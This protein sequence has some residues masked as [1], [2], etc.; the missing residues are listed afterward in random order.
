MKPITI[1]GGGLAGLTLGILLR[2]EDIPV[3]IIEAGRYPRHRVCGEFLSG[4]GRQI[5]QQLDVEPKLPHK[6]EASTCSFHVPNRPAIRFSLSKPALCVSRFALDAALADEFE[7]LGGVLKTGERAEANAREEGIVRATGRRRAENTH[8]R[9][10]GLKAHALGAPV[11][12]DLEMHFG[13]H[14]YVGLCR[15]ADAR[16]NV[17]GLFHTREPVRAIHQS[18]RAMFDAAVWSDALKDA[19]W[20]E[21]SFSSIAA[22]TTDRHA[23]DSQFAI[24]DAA[25]MI[26]PLTGN[27]MSMA[28]E[29]AR[30]AALEI[31]RFS[32]G[33][34]SWSDA[35][36]DHALAWRREFANRLAWAAVIQRIAFHSV[37]QRMLYFGARAAPPI[38]QLFFSRTR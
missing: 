19:Q 16:V 23:P 10:F 17:C 12:A 24:G 36:R 38:L 1:I 8:A 3:A 26:P 28:I 14:Q 29:S 4:R 22:L 7:R 32:G 11:G 15:L 31:R 33:R 5:L 21:D 2:R 18:W 6:R 35:V 37:G 30:A 9:L 27:G 25:A 13:P 20:D 34:A